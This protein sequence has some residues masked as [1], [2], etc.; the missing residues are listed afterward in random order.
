M[1]DR[2]DEVLSQWAAER[3][4]LDASPMGVVGRLSRA[5]RLVERGVNEVL[6]QHGL[7]PGE[8][9]LLATLR[10]TG[11]PFQLTPGALV[12]SSMVTSGAVTARLDRLVDK[13][14]VTREVDP[15]NR[16]SVIV[17]LT[18][19]GRRLVDRVVELHV[20]NEDRLLA[21]LSARDRERLAGLLRTLLVGLGDTA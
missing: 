4:D 16:R 17:T 5:A 18:R 6:E 13:G 10:R 12:A 9:D 15:G 20:A 14:L 1:R 19:T 11:A 8:F 2:V 3:P 21:P 7:A